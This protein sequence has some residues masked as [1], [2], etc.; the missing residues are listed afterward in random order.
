MAAASHPENSSQGRRASAGTRNTIASNPLAEIRLLRHS[1]FRHNGSKK[2]TP[3]PSFLIRTL[4]RVSG[5]EDSPSL[6]TLDGEHPAK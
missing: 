3:Q 5:F 2:G 1:I 6:L 4:L